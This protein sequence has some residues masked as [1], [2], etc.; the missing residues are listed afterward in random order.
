VRLSRRRLLRTGGLV[1][2]VAVACGTSDAP[3]RPPPAVV[4]RTVGGAPLLNRAPVVNVRDLGATGD[5]R[6]DDGDAI[7]R[8]L[9]QVNRTGGT[10]YFPTGTYRYR[11]T[12]S[13]RP[14]AGVT[15]AGDPGTST[16]DVDNAAG[17]GFLAAWIV[18]GAGTTIDG[19]V[20]RRAADFPA[21]LLNLGAATGFSFSRSALVG[22]TSLYPDTYCHGVKLPDAGEAGS[23][24]LTDSTFAALTYGLFQANASTATVTGVTVE[25][26]SLSGNANTDLEFNAPYG[27]I[28]QIRVTGCTFA[29]NDSPGFGVGLAHVSDAVVRGNTFDR[30][31]LEAVHIEDFSADIT[32]QDNTFTAC[33]LRD[34]SHV[35][36]ISGAQRV[37]VVGNTFRATMNQHPIYVINALPGGDGPTAGNR[38]TDP[39][40]A[41]TVE[42]NTIDCALP[43]APL[44]FQG[45]RNGV[46]HANTITAGGAPYRLLDDPGTAIT[47]NVVNGGR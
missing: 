8:G 17:G 32:L 40:S 37:W 6:A 18:D 34:D 10:L 24:T 46:V 4:L 44:Y 9:A 1:G 31:S 11:A 2:L 35:Q 23:L 38:P 25:R 39:P 26:C 12:G 47:D 7:R 45:V 14:A 16:I 27:S 43:A 5:G 13:L 42:Q 41:V 22:A 21:V 33:G 3:R 29:D 36:I 19:L 30:Y 15:I 20:V 28:R